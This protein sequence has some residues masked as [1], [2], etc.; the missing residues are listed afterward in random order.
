MRRLFI[1]RKDLEM[2]AG[3][4]SAQIGHC[5]EEYWMNLIRNSAE[6]NE[7]GTDTQITIRLNTDIIDEYI[8]NNYV[9]TVCAAKNLNQLLKAKEKALELGLVEGVDFGLINDICLTELVA[10]NEDGTCTTGIWFRPLPDETA[11]TI[12]KKYQLYK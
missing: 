5:S 9:K 2:S 11:H 1:I 10:E 4:L 12:S 6:K 8:N 7:D 3:K